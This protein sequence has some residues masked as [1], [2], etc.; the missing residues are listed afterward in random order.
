MREFLYM[1]RKRSV[2]LLGACVLLAGGIGVPV[3]L[4]AESAQAA[5]IPATAPAVGDSCG[6]AGSAALSAGLLTLTPPAALAWTGTTGVDQALVDTT[7]GD[8]T[9]GVDDATGSGAGWHVTITAT[10]FTTASGPTLTLA[11]S[12]TFQVNADATDTTAGEAD[13]TVVPTTTCATVLTVLTT[14]TPPT[15]TIGLPVGITT[16]ASTGVL[17]VTTIY[18]AATGTGLGN[19]VIGGGAVAN[20][21]AWWLNVPASA[22]A[23]T[24]DSTVTMAVVTAP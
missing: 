12:G 14:C 1:T 5:C 3:L 19:I 4:G 24:Y 17:P 16:A 23:G 15:D 8:E 6:V 21:V 7:A 9:F 20:P 10:T 22:L 18:D 13:T 11:D 2:H